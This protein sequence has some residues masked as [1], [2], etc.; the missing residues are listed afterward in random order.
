MVSL[1]IALGR[2]DDPKAKSKQRKN[3]K[4]FISFS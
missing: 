2:R 3:I 1:L 4:A